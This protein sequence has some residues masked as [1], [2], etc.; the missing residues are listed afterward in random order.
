MDLLKSNRV[1]ESKKFGFSP[2]VF[3]L[4]LVSFLTDISSEMI[5]NLLPLFLS[6]VIGIGT[7]LIGLIEGIAES[8]ATLAKIF[9]G[10]LSDRLG[11]RKI[12]TVI[13]YGLSTVAKPFLYF[14]GSWV[15]VLGV[16]FAERLGKGLRTAPRDAL[17]ADSVTKNQMGKGFGFHRAMDTLGAVLGIVGAVLVVLMLQKNQ[18]IL[19]LHT[20]RTIVVI[21]I[22]PAVIALILLI[23]YVHDRKR[24]PHQRVAG[25]IKTLDK[26]YKLFLL[27]M[28][29]F[30]LGNSSDAFLILRASNL[31]ISIIGILLIMA[32]FNLV[33]VVTAIPAG[34][35]SDRFGR[36]KVIITGWIIYAFVYLGF[37]LAIASWQIVLLFATYGLYYG[38]TDGVAKAFVA[39]MVPS[40]KRGV[41]Y[42]FYHGVVGIA[43]FPASLIAGILWQKINP[44]APFYFG[45]ILATI[46]AI[47]LLFVTGRKKE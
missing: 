26:R 8:T 12:F 1:T 25:S 39:D 13:G 33:H 30:T 21:S 17:L 35:L 18:F 32:L 44:A 15:V 38:T 23:V 41:A 43:L 20:F 5:V 2:N 27:I 47:A 45:A 36:K 40:E 19:D 31:N 7:N 29:V 10:W 6:Q 37:A 9:S 46:A 16:R 42:G 4:G 11:K 22:V 34:M 14:A 3:Y 28:F 24:E